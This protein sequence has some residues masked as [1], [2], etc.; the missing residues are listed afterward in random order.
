MR[1]PLASP[2]INLVAAVVGGV[3]LGFGIGRFAHQP[4]VPPAVFAVLGFILLWWALV[5]RRKARG[6][7]PESET[8][9]GH[10]VE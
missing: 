2:W 8:H 6:D 1:S 5:D 4:S 3:M 7:T 10:T 9:G